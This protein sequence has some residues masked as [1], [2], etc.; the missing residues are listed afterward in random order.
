MPHVHVAAV[1]NIS[2]AMVNKIIV[3]LHE[4]FW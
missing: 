1:R 3:T 4:L 2:D